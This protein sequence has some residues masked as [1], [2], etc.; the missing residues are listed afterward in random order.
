MQTE[1]PQELQA[2]LKLIEQETDFDT[3]KPSKPRKA[4]LITDMI[5][6]VLSL[7][8]GISLTTAIIIRGN[9]DNDVWIMACVLILVITSSGRSIVSYFERHKL[10]RL[11]SAACEIIGYY[12]QHPARP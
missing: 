1:I 6:L 10:Y 12:K 7:S 8:A 3:W 2:K 11:Y 9:W 5:I 4:S